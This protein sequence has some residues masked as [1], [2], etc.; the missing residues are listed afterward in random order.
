MRSK[1]RRYS[2]S[3]APRSPFWARST[4]SRTCLVESAAVA[5]AAA[6][7]LAIKCG[8]PASVRPLTPSSAGCRPEADSGFLREPLDVG[9]ALKGDRVPPVVGLEGECGVAGARAELGGAEHLL[10]L[11]GAR[12]SDERAHHLPAVE[13]DFYADSLRASQGR[14][15]RRERRV[16]SPDGRTRPRG[17]TILPAAARRSDR[18]RPARG[19]PGL[20][21][22]RTP[23]T[24]R[25]ACRGRAWRESGRRVCPQR[26]ARAAPDVRTRLA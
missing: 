2:S 25:G 6:V 26:A 10:E 19:H 18:P 15:P 20:P 24:R 4:S 7:G 17:R 21:A 23:R 22:R 3:S 11:V 13:A 16:P 9:D 14:P 5:A 12:R 1:L 8:M